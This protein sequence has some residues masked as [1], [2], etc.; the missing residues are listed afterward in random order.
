MRAAVSYYSVAVLVTMLS[1]S[2]NA[3]MYSFP[4]PIAAVLPVL[5]L[6]FSACLLC[7]FMLRL[8]VNAAVAETALLEIAFAL[9]LL[10]I[11]VI[12]GDYSI[13]FD[14]FDKFGL[15]PAQ[16]LNCLVVALCFMLALFLS[17]FQV[18]LSFR[19]ALVVYAISVIVNLESGGLLNAIAGDR[20]GGFLVNA[21]DGASLTNLLL[22]ASLPWD[23]RSAT[24]ALWGGIAAIGVIPTLSRS[25]IAL[26]L[27]IMLTYAGNALLTSR[28]RSRLWIMAGLTA[29][30]IGLGVALSVPASTLADTLGASKNVTRIASIVDLAEGDTSLIKND[31][32]VGLAA[33]WGEKIPAKFLLGH[34][35]EYTLS[36]F[37]PIGEEDLGPHNMF[38]AMFV[39]EGILGI[40][41]LLFFFVFWFAFFLARKDT[42]GLVL[43]ASFAVICLFSH[44]VAS[45]TSM[46]TVFGVVAA[47]A[48]RHGKATL[49]A[50][51]A[52]GYG[53]QGTAK[54]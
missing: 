16:T 45:I 8:H 29:C 39:D 37:G 50:L 4:G 13:T 48:V 33:Y 26:W 38:I 27:V 7:V 14:T 6:P 22:V 25:G 41:A 52:R 36:G 17:D 23:K 54:T 34:G 12:V 18:Q 24:G 1:A 40:L 32:R 43:T 3:L 20:P 9:S 49:L 2:L 42:K 5:F 51:P 28:L 53:A 31:V 44:N 35:T 15:G 19:L 46:L 10:L 21:N 11:P 47:E 30:A